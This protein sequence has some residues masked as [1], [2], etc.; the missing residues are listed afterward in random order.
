MGVDLREI[1]RETE[2]AWV[3]V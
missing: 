2:R 3:S 1:L